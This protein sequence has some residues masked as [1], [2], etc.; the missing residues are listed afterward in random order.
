V[1]VHD[2]AQGTDEWHAL[3]AGL[4][5]AS[6]F[7]KLVTSKGEPS[8]SM[9]AYAMELAG[10]LYAGRPLDAWEGNKYTERGHEIEHEAR[11]AYAMRGEPV[12]EIGFVTDDEGLWGCSPDGLVGE[13]GMIE[14]K[15]L[16]KKHISVLLYFNTTVLPVTPLKINLLF[17]F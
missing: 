10:E 17:F 1:I 5:T 4:P 6:E 3:R 13:Y 2:V 8:K 15:C 12:E 14:I 7:S 16:P 11:L 9:T